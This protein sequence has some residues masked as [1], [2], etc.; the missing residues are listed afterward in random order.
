MS[1]AVISDKIKVKRVPKR[2]LYDRQSISDILMSG[3]VAQVGFVVNDQ[4]Y[5]IPM[6]Y[7]YQGSKLYLHGANSSRLIKHLSSGVPVCINVTLLDGLVLARSVFH[8]SIN[9]RSVVIFG[10]ASVVP[11]EEK[12]KALFVISEHILSDRWAASREPNAKELKATAVLQV[13]INEA[14]AKVRAGGPVDEPED[15]NLPIWAGTIPMEMRFRQPV[16]D[17]KLIPGVEPGE[18]ITKLYLDI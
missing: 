8:H 7:G 2:G 12:A 11:P 9:Y 6:A 3:L 4:P 13:D 1:K 17:E 18:E 5:V 14:S 16:P 15:Y 10:T